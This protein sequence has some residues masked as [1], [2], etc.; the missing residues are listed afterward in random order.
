MDTKEYKLR[1]EEG[2]D[3]G[4]TAELSGDVKRSGPSGFR[5]WE[6]SGLC[7]LSVLGALMWERGSCESFPVVPRE[8]CTMTSAPAGVCAEQ[9][10]PPVSLLGSFLQTMQHTLTFHVVR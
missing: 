10:F 3:G 7:S 9:H 8:P 5:R 2:T 1:S 6:A 4:T